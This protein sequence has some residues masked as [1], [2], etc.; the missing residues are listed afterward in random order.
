MWLGS[1]LDISKIATIFTKEGDCVLFSP[2][3]ASFDKFKD[4]K[5]RGDFF[6]NVVEGLKIE[7]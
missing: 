3:C 2:A 4:Y 5:E 6:V 1:L 7:R